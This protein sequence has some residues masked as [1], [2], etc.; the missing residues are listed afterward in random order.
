MKSKKDMQLEI[1]KYQGRIYYYD[2]V[3]KQIYPANWVHSL[4]DYNHYGYEAHHIIPYTDWELNTKNVKD[5][6]VNA[7]V[8]IPKVMHQ[9]LENPEYKL[10]KEV[11]EK[12]YGIN[13]DSIYLDINSR[14]P[15]TC[16]LFTHTLL[17]GGVSSYTPSFSLID[18][19]ELSCF[20]GLPSFRFYNRR[21]S[22]TEN[23]SQ[24][25]Y[26]EKEGANV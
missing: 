10:P 12:I 4:E 25:I 8:I 24:S 23:F 3:D 9:H 7:L 2:E 20:D 18:D 5:Y 11:F 21:S 15:R 22:M 16:E 6:Y 1:Q 13:P 17:A 26:P 19:S 14:I